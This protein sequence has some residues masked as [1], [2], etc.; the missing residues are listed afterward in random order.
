[1]KHKDIHIHYIR[2]LVHD[3]IISLHYYASFEKVADIFMKEFSENTFKNIK[4]SL[5]IY[6]H[7]VKIDWRQYFIQ[8]FS[9]PCLRRDFPL[10]GFSAF[11][12]LYGQAV[13][14]GWLILVSRNYIYDIFPIFTQFR[15][16][17]RCY[18]NHNPFPYLGYK[19]LS[20][21]LNS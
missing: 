2:G 1:M 13:C 18:N 4:S 9:C 21:W 8:F 5:G 12:V 10:C 3:G 15:L 17:N 7:V 20:F 6:D 11:R 19:I 14:K 16:K